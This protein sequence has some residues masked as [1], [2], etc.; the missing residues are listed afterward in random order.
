MKWKY[1]NT[2]YSTIRIDRA[3]FELE[4]E[5][6]KKKMKEAA[7]KRSNPNYYYYYLSGANDRISNANDVWMSLV[8]WKVELYGE[9]QIIIC[10]FFVV[11]RKLHIYLG[12][13]G[14]S[15]TLHTFC[16]MKMSRNWLCE[17]SWTWIITTLVL[18]CEMIKTNTILLW[19][20]YF[21]IWICNE[22][23]NENIVWDNNRPRP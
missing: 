3:H 18:W 14:W 22:W 12:L 21:E 15:V 16:K 19:Y 7:R 20:A 4:N 5:K 2:F 6:G 13:S 10:L 23:N 17:R 1:Q 8:G 9:F 11:A